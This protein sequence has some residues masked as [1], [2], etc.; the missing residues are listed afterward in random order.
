MGDSVAKKTVVIYLIPNIVTSCSMF[1]GFFSIVRAIRGDFKVAA[2]AII[3][4]SIFDAIDGR[5]AR[6]TGG[7]SSFGEQYDSL[8]DAISFGVAPAILMFVWSLNTFGRLGWLA[9]FL[10]MACGALRLA[11]FN[12]Q[13]GSVEKNFFQGLPIPVAACMV[14]SSVL[15]FQEMNIVAARNYY[16]LALTFFLGALM[17]SNLRYKN[18]KN[19]SQDRKKSFLTLVGA[20]IVIAVIAQNPEVNLFFLILL[21]IILGV[22]ANIFKWKKYREAIEEIKEIERKE[23]E[24]MDE[25]SEFV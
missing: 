6:F 11:R 1:L 25:G 16:M 4:A 18:F 20:V 17:V 21:Y 8:S 14:S 9:S 15:L 7:V 22:V 2:F 5:V 3:F 13:K 10:F 24:E 19:A 23:K 12:V